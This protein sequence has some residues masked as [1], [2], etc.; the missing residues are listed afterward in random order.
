MSESNRRGKLCFCEDVSC[1]EA[2]KHQPKL[3]EFLA[4]TF[5]RKHYRHDEKNLPTS[6]DRISS[7]MVGFNFLSINFSNGLLPSSFND[8]FIYIIQITMMYSF[9][10]IMN[11][12]TVSIQF[13]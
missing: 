8:V 9:L 3:F 2:A 11:F 6:I 7:V 12:N 1:N 5:Q 10:N 13:L 4:A